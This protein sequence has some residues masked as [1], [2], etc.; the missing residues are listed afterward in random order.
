MLLAT[1]EPGKLGLWAVAITVT[2]ALATVILLAGEKLQRWLGDRAMQ[3]LAQRVHLRTHGVDGAMQSGDFRL[4]L[5]GLDVRLDHVHVGSG[6]RGVLP[7]VRHEGDGPEVVHLLRLGGGQRPHQ[8]GEVHQVP[9]QQPDVGQ[10]RRQHRQLGVVLPA[11]QAE[12]LVALAQQQ[13]G[14]VGTVLAGDAG[15]QRARDACSRKLSMVRPRPSS[16]ATVGS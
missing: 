5:V 4:D 16:S 9:G 13:L 15:D 6:Q 12:D 11:H 7:R 1:R 2:M 8:A 3:A 10:L 14:Q